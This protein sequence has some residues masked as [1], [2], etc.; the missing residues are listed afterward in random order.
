[1]DFQTEWIHS[2]KTWRDRELNPDEKCLWKYGSM[3][4]WVHY[5]CPPIHG[6]GLKF[7]FAVIEWVYNMG[8]IFYITPHFLAKAFLFHSGAQEATQYLLFL[9]I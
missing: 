2:L 1:M 6:K 8:T 9:K 5:M 7:I 3:W 4:S